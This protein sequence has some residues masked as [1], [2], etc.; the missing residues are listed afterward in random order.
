MENGLKKMLSTSTVHLQ[1]SLLHPGFL[2][3]LETTSL[4][5]GFWDPH[6]LF[7]LS[8]ALLSLCS[9]P[10]G[11]SSALLLN[12]CNPCPWEGGSRPVFLINQKSLALAARKGS[13]STERS[14]SVHSTTT[15]PTKPRDFPGIPFQEHSLEKGVGILGAN[16]SLESAGLDVG[17]RMKVGILL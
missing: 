12:F 15:E 3:L 10:P 13:G 4:P 9:L 11:F 7:F 5:T 1:Q 16:K 17:M 6:L 2:C 8:S 14:G